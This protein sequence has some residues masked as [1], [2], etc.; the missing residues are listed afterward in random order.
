MA[1]APDPAAATPPRRPPTDHVDAIVGQWR[2]ERPQLDTTGLDVSA[3]IVR[4]QRFLERH[5]ADVL[6]RFGVTEGEIN[7]LA[8]LRR[9]GD[10]FELTPTELYRSLLVSSGAMTNRLDRLVARGLVRRSPD[11][12]DRRRIRV[13]LTDEGRR[14][15]EE[16]MDEHT[17]D[18]AELLSFLD[19]DERDRLVEGL[20]AALAHLEDRGDA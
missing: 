13:A 14:L 18:L 15:V 17:R 11:E 12:H 19:P 10:P 4:L 5:A 2:R 7:V 1:G 6:D 8:A 3:R 16:A 9:A 20:R